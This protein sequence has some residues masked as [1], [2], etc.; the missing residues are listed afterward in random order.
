L[1][2]NIKSAEILILLETAA[3]TTAI[4]AFTKTSF[5]AES[6]AL[7]ERK[8]TS[9]YYRNNIFN[10]TKLNT[11]GTGSSWKILSK[12]KKKRKEK[13]KEL[14]LEIN[15]DAY[16]SLKSYICNIFTSR[17]KKILF[18]ALQ[19]NKISVKCNIMHNV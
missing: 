17:I 4:T 16:F 12:I 10:I 8:G 5:Q 15:Y 1:V 6:V 7:G 9:A 11:T 13:I 3:R 14:I 19:L 18:I 2:G